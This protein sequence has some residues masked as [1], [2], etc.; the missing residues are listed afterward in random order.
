MTTPE[1][2]AVR[3]P[4]QTLPPVAVSTTQPTYASI[5]AARI[6]LNSNATTI[7]SSAG[8]GLHGHLA[9]VMAPAEYLAL[10]GV[11]FDAPIA[12]PA[13]D[14]IAGATAAQIIEDNRLHKSATAVFQKYHYTDQALRQQLIA[15]TPDVYI[16]AVKDPL[17]GFGRVT[18]LT[19]LT[20]LRATYGEITA[21]DLEANQ[22]SMAADWN[23]PTPIEDLF[24]QLRAGEA[25]AVDG[26]DPPSE[27][28]LVRLGY[29][30]IRKTGLFEVAC[31]EWRYKAT[32][33]KTFA[34]LQIHFKQGDR[35]RQLTATAGTAGYHGAHNV[36][37]PPLHS[38]PN[39]EMAA[40]QEQIAALT[41]AMAAAS[42]YAAPP[43]AI[44]GTVYTGPNMAATVATATTGTPT[45]CWTHG[46]SNNSRHTSATCM[47]PAEGHQA[48]ATLDNPL[49]GS[50]RVWTEADR[51]APR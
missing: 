35:D 9:L 4:V 7:A 42:P 22:L 5:L 47:N 20:H 25:F 28:R 30:I 18:T 39:I 44:P 14:H 32:A 46:S 12:P 29:S 24:E 23:P 1:S 41:A 36:A 16:Q 19:I 27:P 45:Y 11:A 49:G 34:N 26:G 48:I 31:R 33:D 3:F 38:T 2:I 50:T 6:A 37:G 15:A 21:E 51:R 43:S 40:M 8:G 10:T 17:L 13:L